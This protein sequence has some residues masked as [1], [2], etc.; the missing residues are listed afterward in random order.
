MNMMNVVGKALVKE[1]DKKISNALTRYLQKLNVTKQQTQQP[2][3]APL[4]L[5]QAPIQA[6]PATA[7]SLPG[8]GTQGLPQAA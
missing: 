7:A 3:A 2:Q 6:P 8:L 5:P 4:G 1:K